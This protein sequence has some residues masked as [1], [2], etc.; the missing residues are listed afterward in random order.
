MT[1]YRLSY[2]TVPMCFYHW[3]WGDRTK[4][5]KECQKIS[6]YISDKKTNDLY[7]AYELLIKIRNNFYP[8]F[9]LNKLWRK[10]VNFEWNTFTFYWNLNG[11]NR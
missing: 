10:Y 6:K 7:S 1:H 3:D 9:D 4:R 8:W 5:C 11:L 2:S